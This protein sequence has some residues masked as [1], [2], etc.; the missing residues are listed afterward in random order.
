MAAFLTKGITRK[1]EAGLVQGRRGF[2][3]DHQMRLSLPAFLAVRQGIA[4]G[5]K[6]TSGND[7]GL[8]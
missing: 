6:I 8:L 7:N 2:G 5:L 3:P 1:C 4:G